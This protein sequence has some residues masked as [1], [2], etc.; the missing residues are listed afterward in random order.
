[1]PTSRTILIIDQASEFRKKLSQK[2]RKS[3]YRIFEAVKICAALEIIEDVKMDIIFLGQGYAADEFLEKLRRTFL[4]RTV[5]VLIQKDGAREAFTKDPWVEFLPSAFVNLDEFLVW[6]D[7]LIRRNQKE[8]AVKQ[9][10]ILVA[11]SED[12]VIEDII[13]QLKKNGYKSVSAVSGPEVLTKAVQFVPDL[14]IMDVLM[15]GMPAPEIVRLLRQM[16]LSEKKLIVLY[17]YYRL[18][19]LEREDMRGRVLNIEIQEMQ[20]KEAGADEYIGRYN[21]TAF[22]NLIE[23]YLF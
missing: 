7:K 4:G 21:E 8:K 9:V 11:G 16:P 20:C 2:L 14:F 3:G 5:P 15:E 22:M 12:S 19:D 6:A 10:K 13:S 18:T 1:M 17:S 23:K